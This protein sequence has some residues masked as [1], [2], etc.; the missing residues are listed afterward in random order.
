M[1]KLKE[2]TTKQKSTIQTRKSI[3]SRLRRVLM[4]DDMAQKLTF[5][6]FLVILIFAL[7]ISAAFTGFFGKELVESSREELEARTVAFANS[8]SRFLSTP[9]G[10]GVINF[11]TYLKVLS[12]TN[13]SDAWI[14]DDTL[15]I[16]TAGNNTINY[17]DLPK[18]AQTIVTDAF[19][20][21]TVTTEGFTSVLNTSSVT[22][23]TPIY[24]GNYVI[25]VMVMHSPVAGMN[26]MATTSFK[27]FLICI[28][29]ALLISLIPAVLLSRRFTNPIIL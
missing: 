19:S 15:E 12:D 14:I 1:N 17:K 10:R 4:T 8:L 7:I 5:Y 21:K 24:R 16:F 28:I 23:A 11:S 25:G 27:I 2:K 3:L 20:G 22:V 26:K 29:G 9:D 18:S 13:I 6:F